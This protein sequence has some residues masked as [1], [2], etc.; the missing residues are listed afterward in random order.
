MSARHVLL[1]N[2]WVEQVGLSVVQQLCFGK[3][4]LE[5]RR[6]STDRIDPCRPVDLAGPA[7]LAGLADIAVLDGHLG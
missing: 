6:H 7:D 2:A 3:N 1:F 4:R 5:I